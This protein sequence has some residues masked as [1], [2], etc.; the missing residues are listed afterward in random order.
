MRIAGV[1]RN[2]AMDV[3]VR[4]VDDIAS[5]ASYDAVVLGCGVYD[6]SWPGEAIRFVGR[7]GDRLAKR[8]VWLFSVGSFGDSHPLI[9]RLMKKE[10]HEIA[11]VERALRPQGYRVFA[12]VIDLARWPAWAGVL[13]RA[14]GGRNG[15]NRQWP[16]IERFA[17]SIADALAKRPPR[18]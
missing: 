10:P 8:P 3:D 6:G 17:S 11:E 7:E 13:F 18:A 16:V 2:A 9:G 4:H 14:L 5:V 1:L 15:D 12:G